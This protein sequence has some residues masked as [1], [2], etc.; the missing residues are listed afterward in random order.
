MSTGALWTKLLCGDWKAEFLIISSFWSASVLRLFIMPTIIA[1][2]C[3][4]LQLMKSFTELSTV[5][6]ACT[7]V[8]TSL[9]REMHVC[10]PKC[11]CRSGCQSWLHRST[12][13]RFWIELKLAGNDTQQSKFWKHT[14]RYS[15]RNKYKKEHAD[16]TDDRN[17]HSTPSKLS[18][19]PNSYQPSYTEWVLDGNDNDQTITIEMYA[20]VFTV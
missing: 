9:M 7:N 17:A 16:Y 15:H 13:C 18:S 19:T 2:I 1:T 12:V 20:V 4:K 11:I 8:Y 6:N 14:Q 3:C 5:T 10:N